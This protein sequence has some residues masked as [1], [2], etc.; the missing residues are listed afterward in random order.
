MVTL[1]YSR[2]HGHARRDRV[3]AAFEVG[4]LAARALRPGLRG[5]LRA[6]F[7]RSFYIH[8]AGQEI[9]LGPPGLGA[10]PLNL[11]CQVARPD[12]PAWGL[13]EDAAVLIGAREICIPPHLRFALAGAAVWRPP[14][15]GAWTAASLGAGL[16]A[17]DARLPERVPA[18]GLGVLVPARDTPVDAVAAAARGPVAALTRF[19]HGTFAADDDQAYSAVPDLR[20]LIG[21]GPGLTP[22]GDD[23]LGGALVALHLLGRTDLRDALWNSLRAYAEPECNAITRAHLGAAAQGLGSAGLHAVLNDLL[24]GTTEALPRRL[25]AIEAI[26]HTS[27]WDALAGAVLVLRARLEAAQPSATSGPTRMAGPPR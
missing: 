5:R 4:C 15:P 17:L 6:V 16:R 25:A 20:A 14:A 7:E 26:G 8:L 1:D 13:R 3:I 22:S 18:Q 9:C 24:T 10:G 19:L 2:G 21:L 27:G 12:W 23:L 11:R